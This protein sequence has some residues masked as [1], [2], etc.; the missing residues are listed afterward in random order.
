MQWLLI[1]EIDASNR[2]WVLF[3]SIRGIFSDGEDMELNPNSTGDE[4]TGNNRIKLTSTG[5][6]FETSHGD[7]NGSSS[8]YVYIAIRRPDGYVGKPIKVGTD[9][10]AMDTGDGNPS[11]LPSM[12]SNFPV[13]FGTI[14]LFAS[15]QGW[16]TGARLTGNKALFIDTNNGEHTN[17]ILEWDSSEGFWKNVQSTYQGWMWKRHA[18]FDVVTY[19]GHYDSQP[20]TIKHSLNKIPEMIWIKRRTDEGYSWV[21]Y[22][23][24]LNGGTNPHQYFM[25]LNSSNAEASSTM[26]PSAPTSTSISLSGAAAINNA[27][28]DYLMMLF[29]STDVS[30]VGSYTGSGSTQTI[31]TSFAPRFV[32]IKNADQSGNGWYVLDTTRGWG[33]GNDKYLYLN[34]TDAQGDHNFGAPT[35]TGF[36]VDNNFTGYNATGVN[37]LYYC[38]A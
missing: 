19:E 16:Y 26:L 15:S 6:Q 33:S 34:S 9:A 12:D 37:Y 29:A 35:S 20:M 21:V 14:K 28:K 3:D 22:H 25:M 5:F 4:S 31:S 7:Y 10:F 8:N 13:D 2:P 27:N 23:K 11:A 1:K 24:G 18:G 32:I 17:S 38:H 36:T 30:K